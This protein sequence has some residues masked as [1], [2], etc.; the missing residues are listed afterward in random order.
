[1]HDKPEDDPGLLYDGP[2]D[3]RWSLILAHGAGQGMDS[4]FMETLAQ[5]AGRA[6]LRVVRFEFPYMT[7]MRLSGQRRPPDREPVLRARWNEVIDRV[8]ADGMASGRLLIGGKSMGGR[9]AS[10]IADEREAGGLICL[11]YPFHPPGKPDQLRVEHLT[12]LRTPAL[13]CQ[14]TRDPFGNRQEVGGYP[15]SQ[16]IRLAW[17]EDGEHSLKPRKQS[18]RT[19]EQNLEQAAAEIVSF[20]ASLKTPA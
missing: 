3:A 6:G 19:W 7:R 12:D 1:M 11:G 5:A 13:I 15:L 14:G 9:M 16:R 17:I 8:L 10:L 18:G 2:A 4:P 20:A